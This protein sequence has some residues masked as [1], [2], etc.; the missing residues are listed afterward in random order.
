MQRG[1]IKDS[2]VNIIAMRWEHNQQQGI[3]KLSGYQEC[4][5]I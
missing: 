3:Q 2:S 4:H 5:S 1:C